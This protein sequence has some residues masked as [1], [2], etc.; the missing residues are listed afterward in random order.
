MNLNEVVG[1]IIQCRRRLM[2]P[3]FPAESVGQS[4]I[5]PHLGSYGPI[6]AFDIAGRDVSRVRIAGNGFNLDTDALRWGGAGIL[7]VVHQRQGIHA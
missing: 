1:K 6:L 5:A 3:Q 7:C 2:V 4:S